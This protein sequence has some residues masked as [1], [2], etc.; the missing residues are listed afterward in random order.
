MVIYL[1][2][3]TF[4]TVFDR[5]TNTCFQILKRSLFKN[6]TV[7]KPEIFSIACPIGLLQ[8]AYKND[9][10]K[11]EKNFHLLWARAPRSLKFPQ[12]HPF[13][14]P[15]VGTSRSTYS[16][17]FIEFASLLSEP[18]TNMPKS[19][20]KLVAAGLPYRRPTK[21]SFWSVEPDFSSIWTSL[22]YRSAT[23]KISGVRGSRP[24]PQ[25]FLMQSPLPVTPPMEG[26]VSN[27]SLFL[28]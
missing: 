3:I 12:S 1:T 16:Q 25:N 15:H 22:A 20:R 14:A 17:N 28:L 10:Q 6:H 18:A 27:F 13:S 21:I 23:V 11:F 4:A 19:A 7:E 9:P 24:H 5:P 8:M 2:S 26:Q